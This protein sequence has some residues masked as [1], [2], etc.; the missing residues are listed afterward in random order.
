MAVSLRNGKNR[1]F[2][3]KFPIKGMSFRGKI[4]GDIVYDGITVDMTLRRA[5]GMV[6]RL[7]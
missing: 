5:F 2:L 6:R 4:F 1:L 3:R 7:L